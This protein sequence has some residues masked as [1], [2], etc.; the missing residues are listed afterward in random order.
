MSNSVAQP[1]PVPALV[2]NHLFSATVHLGKFL[3]PIPLLGGGQ[4]L[5]EPIT[6]GTIAGPAFNATIEG[7]LAAPILVDDLAGNGTKALLAY[8]WAY[9]TASDGSA[10]FIEESGV[11]TPG[12]QNTRLHIQVGG[13]YRDL[14][15][16]YVLA[17]PSVLNEERTLAEVECFGVPLSSR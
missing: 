10:F 5:V 2:S 6:G 4:R 16:Q 14:Q 1:A 8:I 17:R 3:G 15:T 9:G 7:G 11:G 12:I 13:Q